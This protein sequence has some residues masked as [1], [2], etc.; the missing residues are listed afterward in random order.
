MTPPQKKTKYSG[1]EII[2]SGP[3]LFIFSTE[4]ILELQK[5]TTDDN[6]NNYNKQNET[7]INYTIIIKQLE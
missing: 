5:K 4:W 3:Q 2:C 1:S 6:K 7:K